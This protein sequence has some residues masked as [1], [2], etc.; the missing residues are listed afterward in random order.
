MKEVYYNIHIELEGDK[1]IIAF[2]VQTIVFIF[3][4]CTILIMIKN[5]KII[6]LN[7]VEGFIY[8]SL[9]II[10]ILMSSIMG[11]R[12][13]MIIASLLTLMFVIIKHRKDKKKI[14]TGI[15]KVPLMILIYST[16]EWLVVQY[17]FPRAL[18]IVE[19]ILINFLG[20]PFAYT[21]SLIIMKILKKINYTNLD[22][23]FNKKFMKF[24]AFIVIWISI[25]YMIMYTIARGRY[26]DILSPALMT[27]TTLFIILLV[28]TIIYQYYEMK[29]QSIYEKN[30]LELEYILKYN[31]EL[32]SLYKETRKFRHDYINT[33]LTLSEYIDEGNM[34]DL[35]K[36]FD[37]NI[38]H[39]GDFLNSSNKKIGQLQN[40]KV[41]EIKGLIVT[42]LMRAQQIGL[43]TNIE[44]ID[45][46]DHINLNK[47]DLAR[48]LG[49]VL[50][51]AIEASIETER[52]MISFAMIK[53]KE[54]VSIIVTNS[55]K[56]NI[57]PL[58]KLIKEG[59]STKGENRGL[60]LSNMKEIIS[61]HKNF[62]VDTY[63]EGD[64]FNQFM[65]IYN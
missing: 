52:K 48:V 1:M 34:E 17:Y 39:T 47:V 3:F 7:R 18:D 10:S 6:T 13:E 59:H 40:I 4:T 21:T 61:K 38:L 22:T 64:T 11:Y 37:N 57:P 36:Y 20:I 28:I 27:I 45:E 29:Q 65:E 35:K 62:I 30:Q 41:R 51:N 43:T 56:S 60:G 53:N 31:E 24:I 32:E 23:N 33:I 46:L 26:L 5:L 58:H 42:K 9:M 55:C 8:I 2:L 16:F 19:V 50:D 12:L 14:L 63:I 25:A 15:M 44:V 54:S 49:I